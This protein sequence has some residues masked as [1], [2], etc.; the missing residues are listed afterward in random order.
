MK[1]TYCI[2]G[3]DIYKASIIDLDVATSDHDAQGYLIQNG[4]NRSLALGIST[5]GTPMIYMRTN[6]DSVLLGDDLDNARDF[7]ESMGDVE[8]DDN[9]RI[10]TGANRVLEAVAE[11]LKIYPNNQEMAEEMEW[12]ADKANEVLAS[13][14]EAAEVDGDDD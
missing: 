6:G 8:D 12:F 13:I 1:N 4:T 10:R 9:E 7:C 14:E 3:I 11:V 5:N 2:E